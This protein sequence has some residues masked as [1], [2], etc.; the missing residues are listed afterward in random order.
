MIA[1]NFKR[2]ASVA[3]LAETKVNHDEAVTDLMT[4]GN[5]VPFNVVEV[6]KGVRKVVGNE[7]NA[8]SGLIRD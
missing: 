3:G 7:W 1:E 6:D 2:Q 8:G 5:R 4:N